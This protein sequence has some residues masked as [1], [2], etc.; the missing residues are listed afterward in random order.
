MNAIININ[1]MTTLLMPLDEAVKVAE[2]LKNSTHLDRG[3]SDARYKLKEK[4]VV[5]EIELY[6]ETEVSQWLS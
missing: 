3:Y 6:T 4:S 5:I 2:I 1:N